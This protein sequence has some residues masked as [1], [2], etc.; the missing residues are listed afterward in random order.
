MGRR[1]YFPPKEGALG[2][3]ILKILKLALK[4]PSHSAGFKPANLGSNGKHANHYITEDDKHF[5][6]DRCSFQEEK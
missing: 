1:L 2:I 6:I 5:Y 4:N 3:F